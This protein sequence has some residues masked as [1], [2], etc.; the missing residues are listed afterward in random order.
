MTDV[1]ARA[2]VSWLRRTIRRALIGLGGFVALCSVLL[3]WGFLIEPDRLVV[4][5]HD[6]PLAHWPAT[7]PPLRVAAIADLHAGAPFIDL[8]KVARIVAETNA[9]EPDVIVL[10]GDY[11]IQGV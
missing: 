2:P 9:T 1:A 4:A 10:L 8:P 3:G 7:Y 5:R 6:L 11:V